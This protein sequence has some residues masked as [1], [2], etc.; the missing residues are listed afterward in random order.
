MDECRHD[1]KIQFPIKKK[2]LYEEL[3]FV[4]DFELLQSP[5][6][7]YHVREENSGLQRSVLSLTDACYKTLFVFRFL[8]Y[9]NKDIFFFFCRSTKIFIFLNFFLV[10]IYIRE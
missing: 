3:G 9:F 7:H 6:K 8:F 1:H 4:T 10:N 2:N 5:F